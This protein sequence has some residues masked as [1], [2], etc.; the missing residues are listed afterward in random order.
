ML[1]G[2]SHR[3]YLML[4]RRFPQPPGGRLA[5]LDHVRAIHDYYAR[6]DPVE[7]HLL[8]AW[9]KKEESGLGLIPAALSGIPLIGLIITPFLQEPLTHVGPMAWMLLWLIGALAFVAGIYIH[10]RQKAYSTLH[11]SLLEDL[12]KAK[13]EPEHQGSPKPFL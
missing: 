8:L 10:Y 4:R 9:A 11:V 1:K 5:E 13:P 7:R 6:L 3:L 2:D 12:C